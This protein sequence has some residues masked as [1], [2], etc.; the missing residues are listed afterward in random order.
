MMKRIIILFALLAVSSTARGQANCSTGTYNYGDNYSPPPCTNFILPT[1]INTVWTRTATEACN[2]TMGA[3]MPPG[4]VYWNQTSVDKGNGQKRCYT[5]GGS[6]DCPPRMN[7]YEVDGGKP[8][9]NGQTS[10]TAYNR[11]FNQNY[12]HLY[13]W[14]TDS[15]TEV[16]GNPGQDF[17]QCPTQACQSSGGGGG[18]AP[19]CPVPV[20]SPPYCGGSEVPQWDPFACQWTCVPNPNGSPILI[21]ISGKGFELTNAAGGVSYDIS[22]TGTL[23]QMGWTAPGAQNG[24]LCLPDA[25]GC[26]TGKQLFGNFTP[27]PVSDTPNGFAALGVYDANG[28]GVIDAKDAIYAKLRL[29]IDLNHDGVSQPNELFTLPQLGITWI[30]LKYKWDQRSDKYGNVFRYRAQVGSTSGAGRMAYDVFFVRQPSAT[31]ALKT[32]P[33]RPFITA[34]PEKTLLR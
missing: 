17:Q 11:F 27:Q 10:D 13:S 2:A 1:T 8:Y 25:S 14:T 20:G 15:C 19:P 23:V 28:D 4:Q 6:K 9:P 29:W 33:P 3:Q 31:T 30:S 21:D 26:N 16:S 5:G 22:G 7:F 12:D 18:G 32:C 24:F 34:K